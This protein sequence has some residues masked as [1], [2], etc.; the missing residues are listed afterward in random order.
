[1]HRTVKWATAVVAAHAAVAAVHGAAHLQ[2]GVAVF[3]SPLHVVFI[4]GVITLAPLTA[5]ALLWG[6]FRRAGALLLLTSM[7]A[8]LAFGAVNHYLTPG[9]DHVCHIAEGAWGSLFRGTAFLLV[10]TEALGCGVGAWA[11]SRSNRT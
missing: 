3:P 2:V 8:A 10:V 4:L 11:L 7:A 6:P 1:M 5:V 9:P